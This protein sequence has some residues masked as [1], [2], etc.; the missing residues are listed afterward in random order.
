[1][2]DAQ[3]KRRTKKI[4]R[5]EYIPDGTI[6]DTFEMCFNDNYSELKIDGITFKPA[7]ILKKMNPRLYR[8]KF[9][10]FVESEGFVRVDNDYY[11]SEYYYDAELEAKREISEEE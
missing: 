1:M 2:T 8:E 7:D 6:K 5:E 4:L 3:V 11:D 10:H 9:Q